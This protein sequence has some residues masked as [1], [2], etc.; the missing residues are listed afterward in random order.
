MLTGRAR[1]SG[2]DALVN[3]VS[4]IGNVASSR[5]LLGFCPQADPLFELL[6]AHE[7]LRLYARLKVCLPL[8]CFLFTIAA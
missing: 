3:G 7:H 6:N 4:V 2:G 5:A 8:P 1:P